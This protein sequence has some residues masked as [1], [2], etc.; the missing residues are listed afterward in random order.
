MLLDE[1]YWK[2]WLFLGCV[3]TNV[4]NP[5]AVHLPALPPAVLPDGLPVPDHLQGGGGAR[6]R[7]QGPDHV[8]EVLCTTLCIYHTK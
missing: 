7:H 8:Q 3:L 4:C 6:A 2:I 1:Q 5:A